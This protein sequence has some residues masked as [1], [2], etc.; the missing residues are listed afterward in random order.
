MLNLEF[1]NGLTKKYIHLKDKVH[2]FIFK[3]Y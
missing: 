3:N 1:Y 2:L